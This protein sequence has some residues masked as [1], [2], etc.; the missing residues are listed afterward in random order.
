VGS[1]VERV[2]GGRCL[3]TTNRFFQG[4]GLAGKTSA[5]AGDNDKGVR[6][7]RSRGGD[8]TVKEASMIDD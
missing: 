2:T 6:E 7:K 4:G 8:R 5:G 3:W 1:P